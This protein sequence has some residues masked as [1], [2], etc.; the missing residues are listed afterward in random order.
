MALTLSESSR[1]YAT[2]EEA[3][4]CRAAERLLNHGA[5]L[6]FERDEEAMRADRVSL[7]VLPTR[8]FSEGAANGEPGWQPFLMTVGAVRDELFDVAS[9]SASRPSE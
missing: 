8:P 1:S 2:H 5:R 6:S 4:F 7:P 3:S 9:R